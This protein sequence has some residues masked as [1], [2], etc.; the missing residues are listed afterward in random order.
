MRKLTAGLIAGGVLGAIGLGYA[1]TD[2]RTKR[3]ILRDTKR[4]MYKAN[5][6]IENVSDIF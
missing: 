2:K 4:A 3:R 6:L 1:M 5:D